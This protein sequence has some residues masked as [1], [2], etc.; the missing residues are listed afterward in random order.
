MRVHGVKETVEGETISQASAPLPI[1]QFFLH[2]LAS[3]L[4]VL[5]TGTD[6]LCAGAV[7]G[8]TNKELVGSLGEAAG[9]LRLV[10]E[11]MRLVF[12]PVETP[13]SGS[14]HA[15]CVEL[16]R[17]C[18]AVD[19]LFEGEIACEGLTYGRE[20]FL[21]LWA[22]VKQ[23]RPSALY[24]IKQGNQ[25]L[26][27]G[28]LRLS[29]VHRLPDGSV[30]DELFAYARDRLRTQGLLVVEGE[31]GQISYVIETK[32]PSYHQVRG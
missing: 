3:P 22:L 14:S 17:Q 16:L 7:D 15:L 8:E 24:V 10:L 25:V 31:A 20:L 18:Y 5:V 4:T 11:A 12:S 28:K 23:N 26:V 32:E 6:F 21:F 13:W 29:E 19:V 1:V 27:E 9:R 2:E 30:V